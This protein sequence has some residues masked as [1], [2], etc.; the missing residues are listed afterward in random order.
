MGFVHMSIILEEPLSAYHKVTD[1][2]QLAQHLGPQALLRL[3]AV[4]RPVTAAPVDAPA[5]ALPPLAQ[6]WC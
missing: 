5:A 6:L 3:A 4:A 1:R 2:L